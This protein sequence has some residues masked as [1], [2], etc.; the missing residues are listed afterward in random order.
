[1]DENPLGI[2]TFIV[3]PA[4]LTNASSISALATSNRLARSVD[5]ARTVFERVKHPQGESPRET[6][7]HRRLLQYSERRTKCL[8]QALTAY[9]LSVGGFAAA[10]L[11]SLLGAVFFAAHQELA[12][13]V[14]LGGA[15]VAG[16]VGGLGLVSGS[17]LLVWETRTTLRGLREE[18][19]FWITPSLSADVADQTPRR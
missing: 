3:A 17:W 7:L 14:A 2:L 10:S 6:E 4:I 9:Y 18:A 11:I 15:L 5:H 1:M 12:R 16:V 13:Q 19:D 8:V